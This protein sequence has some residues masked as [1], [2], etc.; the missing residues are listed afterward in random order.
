MVNLALL[1]PAAH[2][3]GTGGP[4]AMAASTVFGAE[5]ISAVAMLCLVG[6]GVV[7]WRFALVLARAAA[8]CAAL[9]AVHFVVGGNGVGLL[10]LEGGVALIV[11]AV[12]ARRPIRALRV[13]D[14]TFSTQTAHEA[15]AA[16]DKERI[17]GNRY[18]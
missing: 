6:R 15:R 7:D 18:G 12:G 3:F 17:V 2:W 9:V 1:R 8:G 4:S 5:A 14:D 13:D 11:V 10:A 16:V